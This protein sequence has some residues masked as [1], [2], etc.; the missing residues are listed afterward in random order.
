MFKMV[1]YSGGRSLIV[2]YVKL[3]MRGG[4]QVGQMV[5]H[6]SN[7]FEDNDENVNSKDQ[8]EISG[9]IFDDRVEKA[10]HTASTHK[11]P[12]SHRMHDDEKGRGI[13]MAIMM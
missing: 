9:G 8:Q 2:S 11:T 6:R 10:L 1:T 7:K 5:T 12:T 3:A 4:T 13:F